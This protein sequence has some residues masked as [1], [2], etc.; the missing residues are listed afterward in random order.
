MTK[1][2]VDELAEDIEKEANAGQFKPGQSG[3][4]RGRPKKEPTNSIADE[5]KAYYGSDSRKFLERALLKA[6]TWEEGLKYAK[7]LRMLQ[8][9]SLQSVAT[10]TDTVHTITLRWS[11]P[12]E[13]ASNEKRLIEVEH[14]VDESINFQGKKDDQGLQ[15]QEVNK[16][17]PDKE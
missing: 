1:N 12:D 17:S 6:K 9:P 15:A 4:S 14:I 5:D 11:R 10:T 7:E 3:N 16:A 2:P 13:I 8:H